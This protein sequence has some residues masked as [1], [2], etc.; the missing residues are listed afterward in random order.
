MFWVGLIVMVQAMLPCMTSAQ[1]QN[2]ALSI[3]NITTPSRNLQVIVIPVNIDNA[4]MVTSF[5]VRINFPDNV[6]ESPSLPPSFPLEL[7]RINNT[8][9]L[10][11]NRTLTVDNQTKERGLGY[12]DVRLT[13]PLNG[14]GALFELWVQVKENYVGE[15]VVPLEFVLSSTNL[16]EGA[17]TPTFTN[18]SVRII[19][20]PTPTL[21]PSNTPIF[22][23]T[24]NPSTPSPTPTAT[25]NL[26]NNSPTP[27][28]L[29]PVPTAAFTPTSTSTPIAKPELFINPQRLTIN[30]DELAL[31]NVSVLNAGAN[32]F[33]ISFSPLT[34][35][36]A[37]DPRR[38]VFQFFPDFSQSGIHEFTFMAQ[39][40]P[41]VLSGTAVIEV[42]DIPG[43]QLVAVPDDVYNIHENEPVIFQL[44]VENPGPFPYQYSL[45]N[46]IENALID[47]RTGVFRFL[48]GFLQAGFYTFVFDALDGVN[49]ISKSVI[50]EVEDQNRP[51]RAQVSFQNRLVID[52]GETIPI[53]ITAQ[54]DDTDNLLSYIVSPLLPN[55]NINTQNGSILF[56]PDFTQAGEFPVQFL[57]YDG[58]DLAVLDR[59]IEIRNV[60]RLP[61]VTLIPNEGGR[62]RVGDTLNMSLFATD[63]D[64]EFVTILA[65]GLP[66]TS[67]FTLQNRFDAQTAMFSFT[68]DLTQYREK[69]FME[70]TVSDGIDAVVKTVE[71][72]VDEAIEPLFDF[73]DETGLD[74]W[75]LNGQIQ[76]PLISDG[77]FF[78]L[79]EDVNPAIQRNGLNIDTFAQ[80]EFVLKILMGNPTLLTVELMTADGEVFG[81]IEL[82]YDTVGEFKTFGIDF[83]EF[84]PAAR[85]IDSMR[86]NFGSDENFFSIDFIGFVQS[87]FPLSTPTPNPSFT[88]T[89]VPTF[90]PIPTPTRTATNTPTN[91]R[92]PTVTPTK[93]PLAIRFESG[94]SVGQVFDSLGVGGFSPAQVNIQPVQ[95]SEFFSGNALVIDA[96]P[97]EGVLL[98]T[99]L[100]SDFIF[101][102]VI[103]KAAVRSTSSNASAAL[104]GMNA[105][106]DGQLA[107]YQNNQAPVV[108]DEMSVLYRPPSGLMRLGVQVVNPANASGPARVLIDNIRIETNFFFDTDKLPLQPDGSFDQGTRFLDTNINGNED[109]GSVQIEFVNNSEAIRLSVNP[110][111]RSANVSVRADAANDF[112]PGFFVGE[113]FARRSTGAGGN[114]TIML[115]NGL[116]S[117]A[118]FE[119]GINV[120][121][122]APPK[123]LRLGGGFLQNNQNLPLFL[124]V[125][126]AGPNVQ[127][128]VWI[129]DLELSKA[130][131][132]IFSN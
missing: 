103:I 17:I 80:H 71:L 18:G 72:E 20:L 27:S 5:R 129:D 81:P 99:D 54:D 68:P 96:D 121:T 89:S 9:T 132:F 57:V 6:I 92:T 13:A 37:Y 87:G 100:E 69:Y 12:V 109:G 118:T 101:S 23:N 48:P 15:A 56:S 95:D 110:N 24:P 86:I 4:S 40:G 108:E 50:I 7:I 125:Q 22:T 28:P 60:N 16:N 45:T 30:E 46:P 91:T 106:F 1:A 10:T 102:E 113:V 97:G 3:A 26:S 117:L 128:S 124:I 126:N 52:E 112:L 8:G 78:A 53:Q 83:A 32:Q 36:A 82:D 51:P 34:P 67:E 31:L 74:G 63:P 39:D 75:T 44:T 66:E 84:I 29:T 77:V 65:S 127:S 111:Q 62:I 119:S 64:R 98:V 122:D 79:T 59:V 130:I 21:T 25:P 116:E 11:N 41:T 85:V 115:T 2:K 123:R 107:F 33:T 19:G 114:L 90:T 104:I 131:P 38:G 58:H 73:T 47:S 49:R 14:S 55:M 61:E 88:P 76:A 105:S 93:T 35:N 42:M 43:P 70:F 120:T 94:V